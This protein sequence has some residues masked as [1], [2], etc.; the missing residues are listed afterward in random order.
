MAYYIVKLDNKYY[1]NEALY[2]DLIAGGERTMIKMLARKEIEARQLFDVLLYPLDKEQKEKCEKYPHVLQ[3]FDDF[4]KHL[5]LISKNTIKELGNEFPGATLITMGATL[6]PEFYK[7]N[8]V[9]FFRADIYKGK[10][11]H[12][13]GKM[14]SIKICGR[15][16]IAL[17]TVDI[18]VEEPIVIT[19]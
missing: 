10:P 7:Y 6:N 16:Y 13:F 1:A 18:R 8:K 12:A 9:I 11:D 17:N 14:A 5:S 3:D 4:Y 2:V 19:I 15:G